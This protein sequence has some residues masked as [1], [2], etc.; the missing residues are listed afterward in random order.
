M[1]NWSRT[2]T[3]YQGAWH[4]G[5]VPIMGVRSHGAWQASTVFDGGRVFEG[6]APDLDQHCA[7]VNRSAKA[8]GLNPNM[9]TEAILEIAKEGARKFAPGSE[10]YVRPM[11]W[12][13]ADGKS[14]ISPDPDDIGFCLSV[15]EAPVPKPAN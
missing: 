5:N 10:L 6:C 3:F 9:A 7:R 4:E 15:Y 12:G 14:A 13:E 11:Y 2:V 1:A 8:M